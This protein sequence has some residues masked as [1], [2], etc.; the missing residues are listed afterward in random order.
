MRTRWIVSACILTAGFLMPLVWAQEGPGRM[1]RGRGEARGQRLD[2]PGGPAMD[3]GLRLFEMLDTDGDGVISK[4]EFQA[5][6]AFVGR[7]MR[8]RDRETEEMDDRPERPMRDRAKLGRP[9][10]EDDTDPEARPEHRMPHRGW[11]YGRPGRPMGLRRGPGS[12]DG[13]QGPPTTGRGEQR[14][15]E[16]V[17]D[18]LAKLR[19]P[20][21]QLSEGAAF[22]PPRGEARLGMWGE[23]VGEG[24]RRPQT[25]RSEW[26]RGARGGQGNRPGGFVKLDKGQDNCPQIGAIRKAIRT[27]ETAFEGVEDGTMFL[28]SRRGPAARE[29]PQSRIGGPRGRFGNGPS[30][31]VPRD[32]YRGGPSRWNECE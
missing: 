22:C 26:G 11:G 1:P 21:G 15:R 16:I 4:E 2:R 6:S 30:C 31:G 17:R 23:R 28:H 3:G 10:P 12:D 27:L 29:W 32:G 25:G 5:G 18:E 19:A 8:D 14:I 13:E 9:D 24:R 20:A 7:R